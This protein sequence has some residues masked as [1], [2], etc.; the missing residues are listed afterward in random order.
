MN[1]QRVFSD[2]TE[3]M[4]PKKGDKFRRFGEMLEKVWKMPRTS[5]RNVCEMIKKCFISGEGS[6]DK[7]FFGGYI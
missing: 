1:F 5:L 4:A 7:M 3:C 6:L 2:D